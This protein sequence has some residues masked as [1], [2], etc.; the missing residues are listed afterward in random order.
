[1]QSY[2]IQD[3]VNCIICFI[4]ALVVFYKNPK[5]KANIFF[6]LH[7]LAVAYWDFMDLNILIAETRSRALIFS[8]LYGIGMFFSACF[9]FI[10]VLHFTEY[11]ELVKKAWLYVVVFTPAVIFIAVDSFT[12][13]I[14]GH[15]VYENGFFT[16]VWDSNQE[17]VAYGISG[18]YLSVLSFLALF[19]MIRFF[20]LTKDPIKKK[21]MRFIFIGVAIALVSDLT[22]NGLHYF[23]VQIPALF[24]LTTL[25]IFIT[26]AMFRYEMFSIDPISAAGTIVS[27]MSDV[28]LLLTDDLKIAGV[29]KAALKILGYEENDLINRDVDTVFSKEDYE[30]TTFKNIVVPRIKKKDLITDEETAFLRKSG[31]SI[32]ISMS[33]SAIRGEKS[34]LRGL[35]CIGRDI[36]YRKY[37]EEEIR[38]FHEKVVRA[39]TEMEEERAKQEALLMAI[40]EGLVV[41]DEKG[42]ITFVNK[43]FEN[44]LGWKFHDVNGKLLNRIIPLEDKNGKRVTDKERIRPLLL[45][46]GKEVSWDKR[47]Y[48]SI[49]CSYYMI[50]KDN[51][52]LPVKV[53]TTPIIHRWAI[54]GMVEVFHELE[55]IDGIRGGE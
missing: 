16:Q 2:I 25:G 5:N 41:T 21:Q 54:I 50:K 14:S 47:T 37:R 23:G 11:K 20:L 12:G 38:L 30:N 48:M 51:S 7:F 13:I 18:F 53:V 28:L 3:L 33:C 43:V 15:L 27:T 39:T 36:S 8:R 10:F 31:R 24:G 35:V 4:L 40:G 22:F 44:S 49:V 42:R 19:F 1:M 45:V 9:Q 52:K 29:N 17:I 32:P 6:M 34:E 55:S 26:I 46:P